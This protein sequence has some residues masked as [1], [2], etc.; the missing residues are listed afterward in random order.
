M[1]GSVP[2]VRVLVAVALAPLLVV[3][4]ALCCC[5]FDCGGSHCEPA[6]ATTESGHGQVCQEA[7]AQHHEHDAEHHEGEG[8]GHQHGDAGSERNAGR[9]CGDHTNPRGC[10]CEKSVATLV[11]VDSG[12]VFHLLPKSVCAWVPRVDSTT[13]RL[14]S[15]IHAY[16]RAVER[17]PPPSLS[18]FR[19]LRL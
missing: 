8:P 2:L 17:A 7:H 1:L 6:P 9:P 13:R 19:V 10:R 11:K 16:V 14:G 15:T 3:W 4:P 18:R 12:G 5:S